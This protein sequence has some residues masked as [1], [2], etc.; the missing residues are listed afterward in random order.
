MFKKYSQQ[1]L[2]GFV[3]KKTHFIQHEPHKVYEFKTPNNEDLTKC[4]IETNN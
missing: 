2:D 1:K 3:V 4:L